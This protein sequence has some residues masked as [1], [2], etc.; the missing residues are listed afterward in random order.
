MSQKETHEPRS[1]QTPSVRL[2]QL[3][4]VAIQECPEMRPQLLV[5]RVVAPKVAAGDER[6]ERNAA[7]R[8]SQMPVNVVGHKRPSGVE[9]GVE[10]GWQC[11]TEVPE[12]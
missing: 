4:A 2:L 12:L 10:M 6:V 8:Q 1:L 11:L 7:P 9:E 3:P 5:R